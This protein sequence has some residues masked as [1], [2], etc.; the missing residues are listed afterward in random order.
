MK[1]PKA[2]TKKVRDAARKAQRC[3]KVTSSRSAMDIIGDFQTVGTSKLESVLGSHFRTVALTSSEGVQKVTLR[4]VPKY[5]VWVMSDGMARLVDLLALHGWT[6]AR[7]LL[8]SPFVA[9]GSIP[10]SMFYS[11]SARDVRKYMFVFGEQVKHK[12]EL[13]TSMKQLTTEFTGACMTSVCTLLY[14]TDVT[15]KSP[16]GMSSV[17][18]ITAR[19]VANA[20]QRAVPKFMGTPDGVLYLG[21]N[22]WEWSYRSKPLQEYGAGDHSHTTNVW[23]TKLGAANREVELGGIAVDY[24]ANTKRT[25]VRSVLEDDTET[26]MSL[27]VAAL[28]VAARI[29]GLVDRRL[30][31]VVSKLRCVYVH[32]CYH[33]VVQK[34]DTFAVSYMRDGRNTPIKTANFKF[35]GII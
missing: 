17:K 6:E 15:T 29:K 34:H 30:G 33:L 35:T 21:A 31:V 16:K 5:N 8:D 25:V 28:T 11:A 26:D 12:D 24:Y 23:V 20:I 13:A 19:V 9:S 14:P 32:D 10:D 7:T 1:D 3:D 22:R 18:S 27:L 4:F 2:K